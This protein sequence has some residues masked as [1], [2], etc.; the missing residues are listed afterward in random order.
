MW[1]RKGGGGD[2]RISVKGSEAFCV[3]WWRSVWCWRCKGT[4]FSGMAC[5][6]G[7]KERLFL[8]L[9]IISEAAHPSLLD[10]RSLRKRR[11]DDGMDAQLRHIRCGQ[12]FSRR[13]V[14]ACVRAC[15]R[16][17]LRVCCVVVSF[18]DRGGN[19]SS[20]VFQVVLVVFACLYLHYGNTK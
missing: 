2:N 20:S 11:A 16:K 13:C 5:V 10:A 3:S 17:R 6:Q 7:W 19:A 15:V 1:E 18:V 9:P 14:R 4:S 8:S 12:D